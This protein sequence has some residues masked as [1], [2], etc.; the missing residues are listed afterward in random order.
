M[1]GGAGNDLLIVD[2]LHDV[3]LESGRG[4]DRGGDDVLEIAGGFAD[5]L[6]EGV[7]S[8]TFVFSEG[9]GAKLPG[10]TSSYTQQVGL[11][12]EHLV[13]KGDADHDV[14]GDSGANRIT[15][16]SGDNALF[17]GGGDDVLSGGAGRDLLVGGS[18]ED[19]LQGGGDADIL[20]GGSSADRLYGGD[21]DDILAGG[22]GDDLLYG[23]AGS[24]QFLIGLND[25]GVDWVSDHS[26][27]NQLSIEDGAGHKVQTAV[28][29]G[30]LYVVVNNKEV[31][32]V[33]DYL[34][35][36]E[37]YA[38]IDTGDGVRSIDGLMAP[39]ASAGPALGAGTV[40]SSLP[41]G[42]AADVLDAWL[43]RP[44]LQGGTG[45]DLLSGT[46]GADWLSGHAGDDHL[47]GGDGR[48]VLE[49]G[50][51]RDVLEGGAHD[52][53]YLFKAGDAGWDVIRDT[54]GANVAELHGFAGAKLKG[55][56]AGGNLVVVANF[57]P[58]FTFENF[59]GHEQA[60]AGVQ[61]G[62]QFVATEDLLA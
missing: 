36:E 23:E 59:V 45:S 48:D 30:D 33:D 41:G 5:H 19:L 50:A 55:I 39:N 32:V 29:G 34:G 47:R 62:E 52:D 22:A 8:A 46:S 53:R 26:G 24:D 43:T 27:R 15:G 31:A 16:N 42:G 57:A 40:G 18:G 10:G 13:L 35:H 37:A 1:S 51:G 17:G 28:A 7:G 56:V 14:V 54:E 3:A 20:K 38:G 11:E 49:G 9:L 21:G 6:P 2:H 44:S 25:G 61:I 12:I 60:F 4:A 58:V